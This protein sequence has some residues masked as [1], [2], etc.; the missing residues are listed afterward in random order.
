MFQS[1]VCNCFYHHHNNAGFFNIS[2]VL[3][4]IIFA[5]FRAT[6][7]I[8]ASAICSGTTN[9]SLSTPLPLASPSSS[10]LFTLEDE[11]GEK[12][13]GNVSSICDL[14]R[15]TWSKN[16]SETILAHTVVVIVSKVLPSITASLNAANAP[17]LA[18]DNSFDMC[19]LCAALIVALYS[20]FSSVS[21]AATIY[22]NKT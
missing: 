8:N 7:C 11:E 1:N 22:T 6:D 15:L 19:F 18:E 16:R 10:L 17:A 2:H 12:D 3:S 4:L 21:T 9:T 5:A 13:S 20:V 14:S